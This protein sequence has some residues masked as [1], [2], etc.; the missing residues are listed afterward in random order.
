MAG[1][2]SVFDDFQKIAEILITIRNKIN[3][4]TDVAWTGNDSPEQLID[5]LNGYIQ[6]ILAGDS[7]THSKVWEKF[8]ATGT[9]QELSISNG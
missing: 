4:K 5:Y 3:L 1:L 8:T 9:Y 7:E 2:N 6:K